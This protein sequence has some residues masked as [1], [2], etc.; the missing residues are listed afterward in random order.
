MRNNKVNPFLLLGFAIALI[1]FILFKLE[2]SIFGVS[3]KR[4]S[5][6]IF[7]IILPIYI[8]LL[9]KQNK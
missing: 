3:L 5:A 4:V 2:L 8:F 7:L 1:L 9:S 6:V